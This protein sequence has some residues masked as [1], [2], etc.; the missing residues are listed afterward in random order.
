MFFPSIVPSVLTETVI[1]L[2]VDAGSSWEVP[3]NWN[4]ANNSV[5][6][7]G[8]GGGG[9]MKGQA[10]SGGHY[11]K[12]S[13]INVSGTITIE[14]G[15]GGAAYT[16]G[17]DTWFNGANLAAS[18]CGAQGGRGGVNTSTSGQDNF[19]TALNIGDL[20]YAG[21]NGARTTTIDSE[22]GYGGGGGAAG[23]LGP[24]G[25]GGAGT[26]NIAQDAGGG[27]GGAN[28]GG[29]GGGAADDVAGAGGASG[30]GGRGGT[31]SLS[32]L[33][34]GG[35]SGANAGSFVVGNGAAG[36][37]VWTQTSDGNNV[38]PGGG[39]GGSSGATGSSNYFG[40]NGGLFGGAGGSGEQTAGVGAN[41]IIVVRYR[42]T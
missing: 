24:G 12:K 6:C 30:T 10:G 28:G 22:A 13:N 2:G 25:D 38:G 29:D 8:G 23:P 5:E 16:A 17:G 14:I 1:L 39:G 34:G 3:A 7:I 15:A 36:T 31:V 32:P 41:G 35:G 4:S 11:A 18:S 9:G 27:G 20:S 40:G 19:S 37:S 21:G 33:D 26:Q 42:H